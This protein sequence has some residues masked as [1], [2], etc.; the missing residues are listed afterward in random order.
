[1]T[2]AAAYVYK[3]SRGRGGFEFLLNR[4]KVELAH[5]PHARNA[6]DCVERVFQH[7]FF[8]ETVN[9]VL[10]SVLDKLPGAVEG[11]VWVLVASLD[12]ELTEI[13]DGQCMRGSD[14]WVT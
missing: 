7:G 3:E 12:Q 6:H 9:V 13:E 8:G 1:M 11:V 10:I 14:I 4:A 2:H 5:L